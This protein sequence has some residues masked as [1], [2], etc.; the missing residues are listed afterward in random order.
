VYI[1][2]QSYSTRME[3]RVRVRQR[4]G[5]GTKPTEGSKNWVRGRFQMAPGSDG[6]DHGVD[7]GNGDTI[8]IPLVLGPT[9][10]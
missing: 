6:D 8:K 5:A 7:D 1:R 3:T 4:I 2:S 10:C 9:S